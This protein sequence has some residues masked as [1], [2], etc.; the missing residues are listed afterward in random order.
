MHTRR[1]LLLLG[2]ASALAPRISFGQ[3]QEKSARVG[4]L[5][6]GSRS[7]AVETG[8][9]AAFLEGMRELG[10]VEGK[11]LSLETRFGDGRS[12]RLR[13]LAADLV[14]L[15]VDVIVATGTA[16]GSAA[17]QSTTSIP[18][19]L[20]LAVDPV[21]DGFAASLARPGG[22]I[23]GLSLMTP[24]LVR[25]HMELLLAAMPK[26]S[27]VGVLS[28]SANVA[29][30]PLIK[31]AEEVAKGSGIR[32]LV[33]DGRTPEDIRQGFTTMLRDGAE[34]VVILGDTSFVQWSR[35]IAE[36]ALSHRLPSIY[37]TREYP[38]FGGLMSY[39]PEITDNMRRSATFVARILR[40]AK[41]GELPFEQP[42]RY[43]LVVNL[44]TARA[45]DLG[46]PRELLLRADRV[47]E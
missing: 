42:T 7:S 45:L 21:G 11:N 35:Q 40:G 23:T 29:H 39:G 30:P 33:A 24:D 41:P 25:K 32:I 13:E 10:Y 27:R 5:Y 1:Q 9:Y 31:L 2:V 46:I 16:A 6:L 36:L 17:K 44:K 12:E 28:N 43:Y 18:I 22:N 3:P 47:I 4:F 20:T 19:V 15:K 38:E 14:R 37:L 8:R 26:L 34:A